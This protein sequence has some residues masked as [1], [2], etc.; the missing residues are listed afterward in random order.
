[1]VPMNDVRAARTRSRAARAAWR[2]QGSVRSTWPTQYETLRVALP[3]VEF[4]DLG[5]VAFANYVLGFGFVQSDL[6]LQGA[7]SLGEAL[8]DV[9]RNR[10]EVRAAPVIVERSRG[11]EVWQ[12]DA[13]AI[14]PL[15]QS[16]AIGIVP[17]ESDRLVTVREQAA[18][19]LVVAPFSRRAAQRY[20][21][22]VRSSLA[23]S[24]GAPMQVSVIWGTD[25]RL[26]FRAARE[27]DRQPALAVLVAP[28]GEAVP[29]VQ[30][31]YAM[32][33]N[34]R[35]E[36]VASGP[37]PA[38]S[39]ADSATAAADAGRLPV[40][41]LP[42]TA[43]A[44]GSG[45]GSTAAGVM[46]LAAAARDNVQTLV[47]ACWPG[48]L[49]PRMRSSILGFSFVEARH[50][51]V[52]VVSASESAAAGVLQRLRL[53]GFPASR[54]TLEGGGWQPPSPGPLLC[55]RPGSGVAAVALAGDLGLPPQSVVRADDS[56]R[57]L[58]LVLQD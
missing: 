41:W 17:P 21:A 7:T 48:A 46:S 42:E 52:G 47:R 5:V 13:S 44:G 27:L 24:A 39:G 6:T 36:A 34:R 28:A 1:M 50:T 56:P 49:A 11:G 3:Q 32:L 16:L 9:D 12:A 40:S 2:G 43:L 4:Q 26:A 22:Q 37:L 53:W 55:Y 29:A 8:R 31:V 15:W 14:E 25:S 20:A 57:R 54:L 30:K 19:V 58:V 23:G 38:A 10:V 45:A 18:R 51:G 35:Q 33:R